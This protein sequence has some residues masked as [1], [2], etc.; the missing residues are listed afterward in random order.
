MH[1]NSC[2][3]YDDQE[4]ED[5]DLDDYGKDEDYIEDYPEF[6]PASPSN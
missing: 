3:E 4:Y 5:I 6:I 1:Y 2:D